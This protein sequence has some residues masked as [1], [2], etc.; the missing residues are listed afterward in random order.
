M[1]DNGKIG[2]VQLS[3]RL[4]GV[5]P[6]V[7][8]RLQIAEQA[9]L[10][11]LHAVLQVAFGWSDDHLYT[12]QIRGSQFGDPGRGME[13]AVAGGTVIPLAA[14]GFEI[15][16]L[17]RY[18]YKLFVP[19]EIDCRVEER[20]LIS[21]D[22]WVACVGARGFPPDEDLPGPAAYP[23]WLAQSS[24][25]H[26]V[27]ELEDLLDDEDLDPTRF[28]QEASSILSQAQASGSRLTTRRRLTFRVGFVIRQRR[29]PAQHPS[30]AF[31]DRKNDRPVPRSTIMR[32]ASGPRPKCTSV[33]PARTLLRPLR[34]ATG[35]LN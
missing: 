8:R 3:V 34:I 31:R 25:A 2:A 14:F 35:F 24:P 15:D 18:Q 28:R 32:P 1:V 5:S 21:R 27:F 33:F 9:T 4:R 13:L 19:W 17:F 26:A 6:P 12:F 16:E 23:E 11:Q 20:S 22:Q 7:T 29:D 30:D 10:A